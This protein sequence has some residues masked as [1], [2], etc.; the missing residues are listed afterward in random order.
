MGFLFLSD[1]SVIDKQTKSL[2][3][4]KF[5]IYV[6]ILG[7]RLSSGLEISVSAKKTI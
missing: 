1:Q 7:S 2:G 6:F 3:R 4:T 5:D